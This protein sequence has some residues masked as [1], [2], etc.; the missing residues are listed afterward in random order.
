MVGKEIKGRIQMEK[1]KSISY[2]LLVISFLLLFSGCISEKPE[3]V[4]ENEVK[5]FENGDYEKL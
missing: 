5:Y 1:I 3:S 4:L 2:S